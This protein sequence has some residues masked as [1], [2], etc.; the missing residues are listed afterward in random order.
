MGSY[1][2]LMATDKHI[3]VECGGRTQGSNPRSFRAE[4][5]G[6]LAVLR[7]VFHLRYYYI[8]RN[9]ALRFRLYCDSE[10]LLKRIVASWA[11][12]RTIPRRFLFLEVNV[13]M[14]ILTAVSAV[15]FKVAFEHVEGHPLS[16]PATL[17][18]RCNEIVS[19]DPFSHLPAGQQSQYLCRPP[20]PDTSHPYPATYICRH[21]GHAS[22]LLPT[23]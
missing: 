5:Y 20:N 2:A 18:K 1:G 19:L 4:G 12:T 17:N 3:L 21:F 7:L 6:I 10:S 15:G 9:A 22:A 23:S 11:L 14:Q 16:W 8:T 13:E